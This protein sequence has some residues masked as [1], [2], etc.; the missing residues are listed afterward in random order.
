MGKPDEQRIHLW[1]YKK[2]KI[3]LKIYETR[4]PMK[5]AFYYTP[6]SAQV[7]KAQLEAFQET[8]KKPIFPLDKTQKQQ[9]EEL[10][11]LMNF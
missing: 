10:R 6:V 3:K 1:K 11:D 4:D 7:N 8:Y 2:I 9:A 5:L